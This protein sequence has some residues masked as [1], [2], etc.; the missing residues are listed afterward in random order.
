MIEILVKI[1]EGKGKMEDLDLLQNIAEG[2]AKTAL[3]ALGQTTANPALST[4]RHFL[5]EYKAHILE[6]KCPALVC[7]NLISF[8]ILP[9]KCAGC[10]ICARKCP[11]SA[12]QGG[13]RMVHVVDQ[14]KCIKCG[15][16]LDVCPERFGAVLKVS[17]EKIEVPDSPIPVATTG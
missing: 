5:D 17:G 10:G 6:K 16:C 7:R 13:K 9:E 1:T 12:I 8:Y 4:I 2:I 3:C 15:S 14:S 11:V